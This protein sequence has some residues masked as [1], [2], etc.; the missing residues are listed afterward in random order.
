[1]KAD[2]IIHHARIYTVDSTTPWAEAVACRH[3]KIMAVGSNDEIRKLA[4]SNTQLINA[5]NRLVLPGLIDAHVHFLNYAIRQ[6][7]V[8]LFGVKNLAEVLRRVEAAV[9]NT[10]PGEWVQGWG[11]DETPWNEQPTRAHLDDIAPH[12]PVLLR[13]LDM[14][15][16]WLNSA[17]L[18]QANITKDTP[19]PPGSQIER[20]ETGQPTGLLREWNALKLVDPHIPAPNTATLKIWLEEAITHLHSLG[21]TGIHDQ[22][23]LHEGPQSFH[24]FQALNREGKLNLRIHMNIA[25][26]NLDKAEAL[27]LHPGFGNDRLWI[28][29]VKTFAD[30]TMGSRTAW[31]ITPFEGEPDNSGVAVTPTDQLCALAQRAQK[32]GFSMS[33]HAIGD[34]AVR[35]VIDVL[36]E[37]PP[38][39]PDPTA[40]QQADIRPPHRIE[41]VQV[42]HPDDLPRLNQHN[43]IASMQP[44]HI[45]ADWQTAN[46]VWGQRSRY[47]YALRSLLEHGTRLALGS[48]APVAPLNPMHGIYAAVTRQ[49]LEGGPENGWY[50][51]ERISVAEAI[52]GFTIGAATAAGKQHQQGSITPGK[53]ADLVMLSHNIFEISPQEIPHTTVDLTIFDG[54]IVHYPD[55]KIHTPKR[56]VLFAPIIGP[57]F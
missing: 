36:S 53:W 47:A 32:A 35:Q 24:L 30:G 38:P 34:M 44:I 21:F 12:N 41:H 40:A 8:N 5:R 27:G 26:E 45:C 56:N 25:A 17:A 1:M 43:I 46:H 31:M 6:H 49:D 7:E 22:R 2:L 10:P 33:I 42:I 13:R 19:T 4:G 29:H 11:W 28:G 52:C 9:E 54:Q 55:G 3:G 50:P 23:V 48:D 18:K 39:R 16:Y 20:D 51:E 57:E 14:H 37:L 15:T